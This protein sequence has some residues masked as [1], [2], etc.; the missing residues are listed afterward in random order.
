MDTP[1]DYGFYLEEFSTFIG[2]LDQT[3]HQKEDLFHTAFADP[4]ELFMARWPRARSSLQLVKHTQN[5]RMVEELCQHVSNDVHSAS[6]KEPPELF[7]DMVRELEKFVVSHPAPLHDRDVP[8][9]R[10]LLKKF[11]ALED[12]WMVLPDIRNLGF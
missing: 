2:E 9:L 1:P 3:L 10:D 8:A 12:H 4:L 11:Q 6:G 7:G 5:W